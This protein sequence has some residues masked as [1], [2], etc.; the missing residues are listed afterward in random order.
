MRCRRTICRARI[1]AVAH[2]GFCLAVKR[3]SSH[4]VQYIGPVVRYWIK[5]EDEDFDRELLRAQLTGDALPEDLSPVARL[6]I[7]AMVAVQ[8]AAFVAIAY[9]IFD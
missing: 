3:R 4:N 1:E 8:L 7:G 2:H 5:G 9:L 6:T